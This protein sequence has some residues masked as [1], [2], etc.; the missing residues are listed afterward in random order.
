LLLHHTFRRLGFLCA[1]A[2]VLTLSACSTTRVSAPAPVEDR[3]TGRSVPGPV[4][5]SA[6][7]TATTGLPAPAV[8]T[9]PAAPP[10]PPP[11][12][13]NAGKPGYYTIKPGDTLI[14]IGL[15]TGQS[16]RDIAR[17]NDMTDANKI[18]V[19]QVVRVVAPGTA[20]G[21]APVAVARP[22]VAGAVASAP[23][24]AASGLQRPASAA[25]AVASAP[26]APVS[27][28]GTTFIWPVS[29]PVIEAF[30]EAKNN[31]GIDISGKAGD[32]VVATADGRVIYAGSSV[33]G[34]G[35]LIILKHSE[36]Y[37]SAYA[38]NQAL[39]VREDQVVKRGQKI[40]EMGQSD[41][42]R[43]KL[44]FEI[45]RQGKPVDPIKLLP[46]R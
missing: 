31:K 38:H 26:A 28:D 1:T 8:S 4:S 40:A 37:L 9:A 10:K 43:V 23:V 44:H 35:N 17:W 13:E 25:P 30:D 12:I 5:P 42:D 15:E 16:W 11:G 45:R 24:A 6:P 14:R 39:M 20:P 32:P 7:S 29:G 21:E 18:E 2:A 27:E 19:G 22:V 41:T 34:W 46:G 36:T 33:R 3:S